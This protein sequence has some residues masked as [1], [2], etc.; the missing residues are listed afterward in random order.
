MG[1]FFTSPQPIVP[2]VH[3]A[4]KEALAFDPK[5]FTNVELDKEASDRTVKLQKAVAP[6]F[7]ARNFIA[8]LVLSAILLGL[9]IWTADHN[10]PDI[11]KSLMTSFQAYNGL[12]VG[13]LGGEAQKANAA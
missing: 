9:A 2:T 10:L 4:L 6:Q 5:A 12:I 13:L 8:A 7:C 3:T 1:I 11:S